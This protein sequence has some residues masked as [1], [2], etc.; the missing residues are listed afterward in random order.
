MQTQPDVKEQLNAQG[1]DPLSS[2]PAQLTALIRTDFARWSK[3]IKETGVKAELVNDQS[4]NEHLRRDVPVASTGE[5]TWGSDAIA[6][7]LRDL[8][9]PY[10][11]LNPGSSYRGL[12]DS[13]VNYLG[14]ERP[15]MLVCLHEEHAVAIAHGYAKVT[16][17]PLL[18]DRAQQRRPDARVDGGLQRM[19]RP[20]ARAPAGRDRPGRCRARRPWIDWIHTSRDQARAGARLR[21]VGRPA[22]VR[23]GRVRVAAACE[24]DRGDVAQ[25]PGR[26]SAST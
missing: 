11:L 22:C 9:I 20:A 18:C 2:S 15:Q 3:V 17:Q 5:G 14:N 1:I 6:A 10:V 25:G 23:R 13:L 4:H 24:A 8:D 26:T 7:L 19:V 16:E 12:H 21:Q